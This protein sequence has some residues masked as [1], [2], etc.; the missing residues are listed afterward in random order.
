MADIDL[1]AL[2][3]DIV[4]AHVSNNKIAVNDLADT[5][6]MIYGALANLGTPVAPVP[7]KPVPAVSIKSS[8]KP[9]AI[10]CLVCGATQKALKRH[11][12]SAHGLTPDDYRA[13]WNLPSDYPMVAPDYKA[14]RSEI[15]KRIGLGRKKAQ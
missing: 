15:A 4:A 14:S 5:I 8:V 3:A 2:T 6:T 9:H 1:R 12:G 11:L 10:T 13:A 7:E